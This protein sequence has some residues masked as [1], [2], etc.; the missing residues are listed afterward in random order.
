MRGGQI[1]QLASPEEIYGR[2]INKYVADFIGSPSMNFLEGQIEG[3]TFKTGDLSIPL[4]GYEFSEGSVSGPAI[5]G[6]RPEHVI[7]G[8]LVS[9]APFQTDVEVSLIEP[10]GSDTLVDCA[11]A[12]SPFRV[13]M[14]GQAKIVVGEKLRLGFDLSKASLFDSKSELRL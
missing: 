3:V 7:T 13:R 5:L 1:M 9:K 12:G 6:I 10:T 8:E 14:D 11:V 2:P 4:S